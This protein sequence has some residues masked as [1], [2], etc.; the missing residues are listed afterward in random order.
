MRLLPLVAAALLTPL[1]ASAEPLKGIP[2][3]VDVGVHISYDEAAKSQL[4]PAMMA[5]QKRME[6]V[7]RETDPVAVQRNKELMERLGLKPDSSPNHV[8]DFGLRVT[9]GKP[10][11]EGEQAT[12]DFAVYA[13]M[14]LD[15][16]K[17]AFDAFAKDQGV[18]PVVIGDTNGWESG[19]LVGALLKAMA[20]EG[21]SQS[22]TLESMLQDYAIVMPEDKVLILCP[23]RDLANT[24]ASWRGKGVS[25]ELPAQ[26]RTLAAGTPLPHTQ[27]HGAVRKIQEI[28]DPDSLKKDKAGLKDVSLVVGEDAK[29]LLIRA[30]AGFIDKAKAE[31]AAKQITSVLAMGNLATAEEETDD[32]ETKYYKME[33]GIFLSG[34]SV[35]QD[36]ATVAIHSAFPLENAK[37]LIARLGDKIEQTVREASATK[38]P[39]AKDNE[40]MDAPAKP[41]QPAKTK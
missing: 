36:G 20:P 25:Y 23:V 33:A 11:A 22:E 13:V 41:A 8:I 1:A 35:K 9:Q 26:T 27:A 2:A 34:I 10:A 17:T 21:G 6:K 40:E 37:A 14:R 15:M 30:N 39:A 18:G 12:P 16:A 7:A 29:S 31:Q 19:K 5:L 32:E 38:A 28:A 4:H 3:D 24:V